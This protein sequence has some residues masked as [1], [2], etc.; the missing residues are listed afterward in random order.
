[1]TG[2]IHRTPHALVPLFP[3]FLRKRR[4]GFPGLTPLLTEENISRPLF[5][6][7]MTLAQFPPEGATADELR[8]GAPYATRDPHL[9]LLMEGS[10]HDM[11][12]L[13]ERGRYRLTAR[14]RELLA[15][16]ES[17]TTAWLAEQRP[18]PDPELARLAEEFGTIRDQL[19][20]AMWGPDAHVHRWSRVAALAPDAPEAPL[21]RLERAIMDLWMARDD[22]HLTAWGA[23]RFD[24]PH[25]D[26]ITH[27]WRGD[28]EDLEGLQAALAATIEPE[29][30]A[31][32]VDELMMQGY[33]E[34]RLGILQPTRAGYNVRETIESDTDEIYFDQWPD[35]D[36]ETI[37][38]LHKGLGQ[39]IA[40]L[41][42]APTTR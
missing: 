2:A 3:Q 21:V 5:F 32:I 4:R 29:T 13:D 20:H 37:T 9:P 36:S 24:G 34:V 17:A 28:V 31:A 7:L 18:L 40:A 33:V 8:P 39:L 23:A 12:M 11:I 16:A 25:L 27:L 1:M 15:S 41:P 35:L 10:E 30:V 19:P 14:G 38:W 22:A 26:I 42:D 6:L